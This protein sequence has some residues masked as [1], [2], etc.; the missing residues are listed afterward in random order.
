MEVFLR[1]DG[2]GGKSFPE[3][4]SGRRSGVEIC[5][6]IEQKTGFGAATRAGRS[7]H[8]AGRNALAGLVLLHLGP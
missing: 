8:G 3:N 5:L 2:V 6:L 1:G 4:I 7:P